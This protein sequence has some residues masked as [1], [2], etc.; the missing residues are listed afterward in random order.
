VD[1]EVASAASDLPD[2][3][4]RE[5]IDDLVCREHLRMTKRVFLP[6]RRSEFELVSD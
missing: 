6:S 2:N 3:V 4:D 5:F 1:V